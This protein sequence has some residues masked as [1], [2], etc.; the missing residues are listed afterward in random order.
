MFRKELIRVVGIYKGADKHGIVIGGVLFK[1]HELTDCF[2][3]YDQYKMLLEGCA[4]GW[5]EMFRAPLK[6]EIEKMMMGLLS[7]GVQGPPG[8]S[9]ELR[10]NG[11]ELQWRQTDEE[12]QSLIDLA[13]LIELKK[14][15]KEM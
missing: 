1:P 14:E 9:V 11:T 15:G 4:N 8:K 13:K 3:T 7:K 12:W 6:D 5:F 2:V 10:M